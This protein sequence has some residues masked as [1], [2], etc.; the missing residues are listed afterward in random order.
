MIGQTLD[1]VITT[2]NP[3]AERLYGY[4]AAEMIGT[5]RYRLTPGEHLIAERRNTDVIVRGER[6]EP[7][8]TERIRKDGTTVAVSVTLSRSLTA[9]EDHRHVGSVAGY[10]RPGTG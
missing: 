5:P 6:L 4:T 10:Q 1:R 2:W 3:A 8:Q 7:Y 9:G